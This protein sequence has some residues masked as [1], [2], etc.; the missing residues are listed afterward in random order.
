MKENLTLSLQSLASKY[1]VALGMCQSS[2]DFQITLNDK[3]FFEG[4]WEDPE[5][6]FKITLFLANLESRLEN[7]KNQSP[8]YQGVTYQ[9]EKPET[10]EF[11]ELKITYK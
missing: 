9:I 11:P 5:I 6:D 2:K 3:T 10:P 1:Q 4:N 8:I 7:D